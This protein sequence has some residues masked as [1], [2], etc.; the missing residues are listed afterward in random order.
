MAKFCENCGKKSGFVSGDPLLL[1]SD[2][3]LCSKC[4]MQIKVKVDELYRTKDANNF[5]RLKEEILT[6]SKEL[7]NV[8]VVEEL[9]G[10]IDR[11]AQRKDFI[12][13]QEVNGKQDHNSGNEETDFTIESDSL[14]IAEETSDSSK[15]K[16]ISFLKIQN[17]Q[18]KTLKSIEAMIKFFVVLTIISLACSVISFLIMMSNF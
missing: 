7:Y 12:L 11:I 6:V 1:N 10:L 4:A 3:I 2:K 9:K 18:L 17:E 13:N 8:S 5:K 14:P 15:V 16:D